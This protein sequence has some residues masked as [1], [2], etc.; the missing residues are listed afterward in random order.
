MQGENRG[1]TADGKG[2]VGTRNGGRPGDIRGQVPI[3]CA[4]CLLWDL[5]MAQSE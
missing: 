5:D 2:W 3:A 1:P 4:D